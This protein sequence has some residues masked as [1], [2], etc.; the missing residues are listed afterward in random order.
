MSD[1]RDSE[2]RYGVLDF[3]AWNHEWNH[4]HYPLSHIRQSLA[5]MRE[6]GAA[7]V[8][9]DFLWSDI[10]PTPDR[11][12]FEKYDALVDTILDSGLKI[13]GL[14]LY[15]PSWQGELW[16]TAPHPEFYTDF[17]QKVV[18]RYKDRVRHWEIWNEPD[19]PHFWQPQDGLHAYIDLLK[20][21]YPR[22][23]NE[24]DTCL[25]HLAGMSKGLP[26][27]LRQ[28]YEHGAR[29]AFDIAHVHPFSDPLHPESM[30][31]M[32][33][34]YDQ[35][36][37]AMRE[38]GDGEK[39]IWFTEIGCPGMKDP[40]TTTPWW[41]GK[42]SNEEEQA[43]WV[44]TVYANALQWPGVDKVFWAFFRD[45]PDHFKTGEDHL[46]LIRRDFSRKP[47]F[48]AYQKMVAATMGR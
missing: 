19:H 43:E 9:M 10:Q 27:S 37:H 34:L 23:K 12:E 15:S 28:V 39:P 16:N 7:W 31:G 8:R 32:R 18:R 11:W 33:R 25:V 45:T 26:D 17:A 30:A 21:V 4:Y 24:D 3:F 48:H 40:G 38:A 6:A 13:L 22:L 44:S 5:L 46:G 41:F 35:V 1:R 29:E 36:H 42:N 2:S 14:L 47:A 20:R